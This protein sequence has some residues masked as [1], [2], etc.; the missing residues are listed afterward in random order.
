M[1]E[2]LDRIHR[3]SRNTVLIVVASSAGA[4]AFAFAAFGLKFLLMWYCL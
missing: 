3:E 1:D 2:E 4:A